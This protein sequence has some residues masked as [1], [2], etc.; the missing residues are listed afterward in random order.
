MDNLTEQRNALEIISNFIN[1]TAWEKDKEECN[2]LKDWVKAKV[3]T[4]AI[5]SDTFD[6][7]IDE[8]VKMLCVKAS[9]KCEKYAIF[10]SDDNQNTMFVWLGFYLMV[11]NDRENAL[12]RAFPYMMG[13]SLLAIYNESCQRSD[14]YLRYPRLGKSDLGEC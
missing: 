3:K 7:A 8:L 1:K 14:K 11:V 4:L 10:K 5:Y 6:I 12:S 13:S 9:E 2:K